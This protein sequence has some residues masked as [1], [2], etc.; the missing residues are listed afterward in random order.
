MLMCLFAFRGIQ[1]NEAL[2]PIDHL[3]PELPSLKKAFP[4]QKWIFL[5]D[6]ND[7]ELKMVLEDFHVSNTKVTNLRHMY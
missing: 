5:T 7:D 4:E 6:C 3:F 1:E 2:L